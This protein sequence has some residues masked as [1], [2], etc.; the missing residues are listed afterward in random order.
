MW[1]SSS[2]GA[3]ASNGDPSRTRLAPI[4]PSTATVSSDQTAR[5]VRGVGWCSM[6]TLPPESHTACTAGAISA[7]SPASTPTADA[8]RRSPSATSAPAIFVASSCTSPQVLRCGALGSPV[9]NPL[10]LS[11]AVANSVSTN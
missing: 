10:V 2:T 1:C 5:S 6:V 9:T 4:M 8:G 11:R 3:S 7:G